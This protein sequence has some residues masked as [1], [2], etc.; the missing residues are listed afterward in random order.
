VTAFLQP[1]DYA[2]YQL[3]GH[4]A[5]DYSDASGTLLFDLER[6]AWHE[7]FLEAL[8]LP[9]A[10]LPALYPSS[11]VVGE[12]TA[13]AAAASGLAP[14]TP[15]VIGGG[16]GACAGVGAGVVEPGACY[17][18]IGSSAW[19][20][21][22]SSE[23]VL[24][25]Q[26]R[27]FTFHHLH[28]ERYCP[29]GT[30]QAAGGARD[31]AW[32]LLQDAELDLDSAAAQV[33]PGAGGLICLPYLLGERSPHWNPLARGAFVGLSMPTGK[34]E[35]A[36]AVLEGV[37]LNLRLILDALRSQVPTISAVRLIG[38]GSN[39]PLWRQ[40][41]ADCFQLPIHLLALKSEATSWGAA[42]AGGVGVGLYGWELAAE[43]GQVVATVEPDMRAAA[44]YDEVAAVYGELYDALAPI[45]SKLARLQ[46]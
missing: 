13:A 35:M 38:G 25:P 28:P 42:V 21:I 3:T 16:D 18:Y 11:T 6:R 20:S 24:D 10:R 9:A 14:G 19:I 26:Q 43:R 31:W 41:L 8:D 29:M 34:A 45:Y 5:T 4:F 44:R 36:R 17:C 46:G 2:V 22:S 15:V 37:A 1:K 12:V 33:A 23:P 39:S 40:I 7:P 32:R 30:M 27:T